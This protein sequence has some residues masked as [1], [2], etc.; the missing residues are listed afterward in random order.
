MKKGSFYYCEICNNL[1]KVID[2]NAD[3]LV[4]CGQPMNLLE[5]HTLD[6]GKEKHVPVI[7]PEGDNTRVVLGEV[8]H[9]MTEEHYIDFIQVETS[10][11]KIGI[12]YVKGQEK[13][14]AVF[15]LKAEEIVDVVAYCNLH[16]LWIVKN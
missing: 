15:N 6:S 14:E 13:A 5:P 4:C 11:G 9:P 10:A 12:Q 1:V 3:A 16:G 7:I 8:P 2:A